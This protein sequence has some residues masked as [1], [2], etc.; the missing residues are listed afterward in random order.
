MKGPGGVGEG[1]TAVSTLQSSEVRY[2]I[3]L[4]SNFM[5]A[6]VPGALRP[7]RK[8]R[9]V[10]SRREAREFTLFNASG[11]PHNSKITGT[12]KGGS[13]RSGIKCN[14]VGSYGRKKSD[15]NSA[16]GEALLGRCGPIKVGR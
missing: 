1:P 9:K 14:D 15:F 12:C 4:V 7:G 11:T 8:G 3:A 16:G 2:L 10:E 6:R 5:V 13:R